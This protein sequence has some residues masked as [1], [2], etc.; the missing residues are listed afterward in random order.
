MGSRLALIPWFD[1][2][3]LPST[4]LRLCVKQA[5]EKGLPVFGI[6]KDEV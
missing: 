2:L 3:A 1:F 4:P 5:A 6:R